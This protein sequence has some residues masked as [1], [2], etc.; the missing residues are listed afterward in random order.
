MPTVL[1]GRPQPGWEEKVGRYLRGLRG[2]RSVEELAAKGGPK[3]TSAEELLRLESGNLGSLSFGEF[4]EICRRCYGVEDVYNC[5]PGSRLLR[6]A[7]VHINS[8]TDCRAWERPGAAV[9]WRYFTERLQG[10]MVQPEFLTLPGRRQR[11]NM[12]VTTPGEHQG[13]E[14]VYVISGQPK[15]YLWDAARGQFAP[16]ELRRGEVLHF[17]SSVR[18]YV[19]NADSYPAQL[20]IVRYVPPVERRRAGARA[21]RT[22]GKQGGHA[23]EPSERKPPGKAQ[24][25]GN[26]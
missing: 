4:A 17:R 18:H 5:P 12:G 10:A 15:M 13:E 2:R 24:R 25:L 23:P 21:S 3:V 20:L 19:E 6:E 7:W 26:E 9:G 16:V 22:R 8:E 14:L 11:K 1:P